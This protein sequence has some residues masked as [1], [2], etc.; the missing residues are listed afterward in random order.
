[1][2]ELFQTL[3]PGLPD[4][5]IDQRHAGL[6]IAAQNPKLALGLAKLSAYIAGELPWCLRKDL[7]ELAIQAVNVHFKSEYSFNARMPNALAAGIDAQRQAALRSWQTSTLFTEEQRLVIE[8]AEA[9]VR[10]EVSDELFSRIVDAHGEKQAVECTAVI[11]FWSFWA[12]FLKA[13]HP[14]TGSFG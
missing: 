2:D 3:M 7:R 13:T 12:I 4:P 11:A 14:E 6:A 10:G 1:M 5:Q 9:A 8:Y